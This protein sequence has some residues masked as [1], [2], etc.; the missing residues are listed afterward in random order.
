MCMG[1]SG[2][3]TGNHDTQAYY[4]NSKLAENFCKIVGKYK[5]PYAEMGVGEGS[6]FTRL[7][8]PKMGVELRTISPK[9]RGV[10]Y[11]VDALTWIPNRQ[12]GVIVMNPPFAKQIEFFN[13]ASDKLQVGRVIIWIA[14][15]NI[16]LWTNEDLLDSKM[17]LE[18]EWL[19]PPEWSR[20]YTSNG[21]VNIRTVVQVWRKQQQPRKL[22]KLT[23]IPC[24][25]TPCRDQL[26][27]P[28]HSLVVKRVG[29]PKDVGFSI[30]LKDCKKTKR[31]GNVLKTEC[32]TLQKGWGTAIAFEKI[33][34]KISTRFMMGCF[35]HLLQNR[36][37]SYS[38]VS[39]SIPIINAILSEHW[40][41]LI[42]HIDYLDGTRREKHQW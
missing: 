24:S 7:P 12:P 35:Y 4:T 15:L 2:A 36:I 16:R 40:R 17:H 28:P 11:G 20:F 33:S 30:V 14:G 25:V 26:N 39:L 22:W 13:H 32:G 29:A 42:R 3:R 9:I 6:I 8:E 38:L 5:G 37:Y 19:V 41:Q 21:A 23:D 18:K 10:V 1:W 27:P 31:T 34:S